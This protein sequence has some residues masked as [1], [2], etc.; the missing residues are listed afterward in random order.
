MGPP[1]GRSFLSPGQVGKNRERATPPRSR[2]IRGPLSLSTRRS[3]AS[4]CYLVLARKRVASRG[5]AR[6][7][8]ERSW[9]LRQQAQLRRRRRCLEVSSAPEKRNARGSRATVAVFGAAARP[10]GFSEPQ[11]VCP[12]ARFICSAR[13]RSVPA[14]LR[15]APPANQRRGQGAAPRE[16]APPPRGTAGFRTK[17]RG[18]GRGAPLC[19]LSLRGLC[20]SNSRFLKE[21]RPARRA[22]SGSRLAAPDRFALSPSFLGICPN[23]LS[24]P[25]RGLWEAY[26]RGQSPHVTHGDIT[27]QRRWR[28]APNHS[29]RDRTRSEVF[30]LPA[31]RSLTNS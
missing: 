24:V 30:R 12:L 7:I 6:A 23:P 3:V 5:A 29:A 31:R 11:V 22:S 25:Q 10:F 26:R 4:R 15:P 17:G 20:P 9:P 19:L 21:P 16:P 14:W 8:G 1:A 28:L 27:A 2:R 13:A 18:R